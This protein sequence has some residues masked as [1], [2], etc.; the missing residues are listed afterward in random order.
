MPKEFKRCVKKVA[1]QKSTKS[2]YAICTAQNAG[3]IKGYLA[4][5]AKGRKLGR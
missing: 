5:K 1:R 4:K 3:N 2:A